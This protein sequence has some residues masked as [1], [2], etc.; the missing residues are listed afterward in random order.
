VYRRMAKAL[1]PGAPL[2]FTYHHNK[3]EAYQAIGV[4]ILDAG[5]TCSASFPCPAEMGGS[6]HIHGTASSIVDTVFVCR[7]AGATP[8][9]WLFESAEGL[10]AIVADDLTQLRE[11]GLKPTAGDTRCIIYG[12]LARMSVWNLRKGWKA[13]RPA[14]HKLD[15]FGEAMRALADPEDLV[16]LLQAREPVPFPA[17]PLF[18]AAFTVQKSRDAVA[19]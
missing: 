1:K 19:V 5:F 17:G 16:A 8:R 3:L 15:C 4:A 6:I 13:D 10:T 11:G 14:Q 9:Q 7:S 2:V 18:A 12:H